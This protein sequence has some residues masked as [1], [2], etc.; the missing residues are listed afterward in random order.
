ME[1]GGLL[2]QGSEGWHKWR[3]QGLGASE[4]P[5]I[6]GISPYKTRLELWEEKTGKREPFKGNWATERGNKLEPKARAN[7][8]LYN[9][10]EMKPTLAEHK[11][12]P[13]IKCSLDGYN[14]EA[15]KFLE[16][17]CP[18]KSDHQK[19]IN[20]EVPD[21]YY[22]QI[23]HQFLVTGC[24]SGDYFS[25]DG[26]S[27]VI[28]TVYPDKEYCQK[29]LE[30][31]IAFWELVKTNIPPE[32]CEKDFP[33]IADP[34]LESYCEEWKKLKIV[35]QRV[36]KDLKILEDK[37]RSGLQVP[38]GLCNGVKF[39]KTIRKGNIDYS[40]IEVLKDIEL[41]NFRRPSV[42]IFNIRL[43]KESK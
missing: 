29:L 36:E 37:I 12:Y 42:E 20:G 32:A 7:Y 43:L 27:G 3:L 26:E 16:I 22:P 24:K 34:S 8:E 6:M 10:I 13:F 18:G 14:K 4:S 19:A 5:T 31:L 25:F 23:Q 40:L 35:S 28:V 33:V 2:D 41:E 15:S 17:K 38:R 1:T 9:Q 30:E 39:Y 11:D 21:K